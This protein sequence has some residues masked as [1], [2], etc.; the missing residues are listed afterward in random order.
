MI[1]VMT[2]G[3]FDILHYGHIRLLRRAK[4]LGDYLVVVCSNDECVNSK[5]KK[6]YYSFDVRKEMLNS[7]KFV[8]EVIEENCLFDDAL[9]NLCNIAIEKSIDIFVLGTDYQD[10]LSAMRDYDRLSKLVKIV[11]L[12]RTE[13]ISTSKIKQDLEKE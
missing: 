4:E 8:D 1:K 13:S 10:S 7:I 12:E 6:C 9:T 11:F 2:S 5:G 3:T